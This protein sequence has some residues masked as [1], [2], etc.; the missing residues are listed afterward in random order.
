MPSRIKDEAFPYLVYGTTCLI[1]CH[2]ASSMRKVTTR[3]FRII[4]SPRFP[5]PIRPSTVLCIDGWDRV[6]LV[7]MNA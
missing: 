6:G 1:Q 3:G 7:F 4:P 2:V 5:S